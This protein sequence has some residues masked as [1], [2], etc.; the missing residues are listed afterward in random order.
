MRNTDVG[1]MSSKFDCSR[2]EL[3]P[4]LYHLDA[5]DLLPKN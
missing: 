5:G 4:I 3:T 1:T 2:V